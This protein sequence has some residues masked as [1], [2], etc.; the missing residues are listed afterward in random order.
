MGKHHRILKRAIRNNIKQF[1]EVEGEKIP[2][3]VAETLAMYFFEE[4]VQPAVSTG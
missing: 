3:C 1:L 2:A 4:E